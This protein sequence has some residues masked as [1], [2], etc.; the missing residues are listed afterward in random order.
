MLYTVTTINGSMVT[1]DK[2]PPKTVV[3]NHNGLYIAAVC[4]TDTVLIMEPMQEKF[5][6]KVGSQ[7]DLSSDRSALRYNE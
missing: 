1:L 5:N 3:G 7:L 2:E 6:I 4:W